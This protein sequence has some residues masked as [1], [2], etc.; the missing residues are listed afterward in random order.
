MLSGLRR[1]DDPPTAPT[2]SGVRPRVRCAL[3]VSANE[4][5]RSLLVERLL[6]AGFHVEWAADAKEAQERAGGSPPDVVVVEH[7]GDEPL[8][9][10]LLGDWL[11]IAVKC[12]S[13]QHFAEIARIA[14]ALKGMA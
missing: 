5:S 14:D 1:S 2:R 9:A 13:S 8:S 3:I 11:T 7:L 10:Q 6:A 12:G 4:P